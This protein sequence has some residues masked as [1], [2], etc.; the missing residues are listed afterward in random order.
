M[1]LHF[2]GKGAA[3]YPAFGN[4]NAWFEYDN[5][6]YF[7]DFGES[8]FEKV[9]RTIDLKKYRQ[10]YVLLT[11]LHADHAGSLASFMSYTSIV[12]GLHVKV[13]H[14]VDTVV[15]LLSIMGISKSFYD[16][17]PA[18]PADCP[19]TARPVPVRHAD[20]MKTFGYVISA[21]D[22]CFYFSGDSAELPADIR[23]AFLTG[24]IQNIY[25]DTASHHS[26]SHCHYE[27]LE[28]VIPAEKRRDF[29][30]MHLDADIVDLLR[31][32]GFS[33]V[34]TDD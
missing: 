29:Y 4:T 28:A 15:Q 25:H 13:V 27:T 11:H 3:F 34:E 17:L 22:D 31:S 33:V 12:L 20:D 18:L 7:L 1:K 9:V 23:D 30:C 19:V 10:I 26:P 16:Y 14:P 6:L 21:G 5:D 8:S 2:L 24:Q 32:K